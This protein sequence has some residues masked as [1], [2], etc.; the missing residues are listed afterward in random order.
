MSQIHQSKV[1]IQKIKIKIYTKIKHERERESN[2]LSH[3]RKYI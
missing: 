1:E 2:N 3:M